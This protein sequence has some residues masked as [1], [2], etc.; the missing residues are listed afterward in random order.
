M[1][2]NDSKQ[3]EDQPNTHI[4]EQLENSTKPAV[5]TKARLWPMPKGFVN[6]DEQDEAVP[7]IFVGGV[8]VPP[9]EK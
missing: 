4:S 2:T 1:T 8:R 9:R 7:H 3:P 5:P 6:M